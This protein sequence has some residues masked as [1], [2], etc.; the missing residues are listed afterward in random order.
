MKTRKILEVDDFSSLEHIF[1]V[2]DKN[3]KFL[4]RELKVSIIINPEGVLLKGNKNNVE[5][6]SDF[7]NPKGRIPRACPWMNGISHEGRQAKLEL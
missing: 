2:E 7:I 5:G 1:G 4:E 3:L 6:A